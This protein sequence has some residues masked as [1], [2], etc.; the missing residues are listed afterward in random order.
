MPPAANTAND[1]AHQQLLNQLD[2]GVLPKPFRNPH[3]KPSQRR[4]KNLK[5][6]ISENSRKEASVLATQANSGA[7]TPFTGASAAA[8]DGSQ[9]PAE[10]AGNKA[11]NLAQ[12]S[13]NLSTLV[14]EKNAR[15]YA[16][17]PSVTY[18]NIESAPSLNPAHQRHYCDLTGLPAPYTDPKT[19]LRYHDKEIFGVIRHLAQGVPES[20]LEARGAHTVLK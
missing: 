4:N 5:Q 1:E 9:T 15:A 11:P 12:A 14:L 2:I 8:T 17:G 13:Q 10:G 6:I 7:T 20:Y 18:T 3:W 19:R 16:T